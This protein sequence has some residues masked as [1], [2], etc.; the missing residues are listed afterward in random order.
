LSEDLNTFHLAQQ[1]T[2]DQPWLK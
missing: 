1:I 2:F